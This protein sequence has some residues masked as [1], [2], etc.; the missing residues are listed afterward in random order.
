MGGLSAD[1]SSGKARHGGAVG[2]PSLEV[3]LTDRQAE[4]GNGRSGKSMDQ[5][6]AA[7]ILEKLS[8]HLDH[9]IELTVFGRAALGLAFGA[10]YPVAALSRDVDVIIPGHLLEVYESD[11]QMWDAIEQTN[12][13]LED[14]GLYLTHLFE[15]TQVILRPDWTKQRVPLEL[16]IPKIRLFRPAALD[17]ILSKMMRGLDEEDLQDAAFLIGRFSLGRA[18]LEETIRAARLST[19]PEDIQ[20]L[21]HLAARRILEMVPQ[22]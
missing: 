6:N 4:A 14:R 3:L 21:F 20:V 19:I 15:D 5:S 8:G 9:S 11:L 22:R 13:D 7:V 2:D 12:R 18:E 17:L 10:D 16:R 1:R